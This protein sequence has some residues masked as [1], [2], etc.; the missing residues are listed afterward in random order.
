MHSILFQASLSP[1][2]IRNNLLILIYLLA[3]KCTNCQFLALLGL[4]YLYYSICIIVKV[5]LCLSNLPPTAAAITCLNE[6]YFW[7][8]H[9]KMETHL[10]ISCLLGMVFGQSA[11]I[12]LQRYILPQHW[13]AFIEVDGICLGPSVSL[14]QTSVISSTLSEL[15]L[16]F[17]VEFP[18][19]A[20]Y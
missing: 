12:L 5:N 20:T 9:A 2:K 4:G 18:F 7:I 10:K 6:R 11:L 17:R 8:L 1:K 16:N 3:D 14:T 19:H 13:V 15:L